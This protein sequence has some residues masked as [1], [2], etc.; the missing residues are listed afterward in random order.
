MICAVIPTYKAAGTVCGVVLKL[1][2][3]V[4]T[5]I[6]VDD[7]CPEGSAESV[8]AAFPL[9]ARVIV[10]RHAKNGGVGRATKTGIA[11]ALELGASVVFK[12]DADDQMD[13]AYIPGIVELFERDPGLAF[14]KGNR[15]YRAQVLRQMPVVRLIGNAVLSLWVKFSS[16]YWNLLDPTNGYMAFNASVL[17]ELDWTSFADSYFFEISVLCALGLRQAHIAEVEMATIYGSERSSLSIRRVIV[18]FPFRLL[19]IFMRRVLLQY[20]VFDVNVG[21]LNLVMGTLLVLAGAAFGSYEW[22]ETATTGI[23]R[24]AGT[25]MLAA[26]PVLMG[27]QLLLNALMYDVQFGS[28]SVRQLVARDH[29]APHPLARHR[30]E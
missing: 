14:V 11:K 1:L 23:S 26:L 20:F 6:V 9:D 13:V 21:T 30:D 12:I 25:I 4:D 22:V 8:Q 29:R 19:A 28:K 18:E 3:L 15:F 24:S 17:G 16:G 27:F 2:P 10:L 5:V 7:A